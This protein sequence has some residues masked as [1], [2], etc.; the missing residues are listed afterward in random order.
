MQ[1]YSRREKIKGNIDRK[2]VAHHGSRAPHPLFN[3]RACKL[4]DFFMECHK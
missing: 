2:S 4:P 1:I 3:P